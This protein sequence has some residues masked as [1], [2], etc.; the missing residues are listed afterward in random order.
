MGTESRLTSPGSG[1]GSVRPLS[2]RELL[3]VGALGSALALLPRSL[4]AET[5][6]RPNIL[7]VFIDDL[8]A[9]ALGC[10]GGLSYETPRIDALAAGGLRFENCYANPT[11]TPSRGTLL[12]G[13][14]P[15]RIGM[16]DRTRPDTLLDPSIP[17]FAGQLR[18]AGYRTA[19]SGK[20]Q[21]ARLD[22]RPEH[23]QECGFDESFLW[24]WRPFRGSRRYWGADIVHNGRPRPSHEGEYGPD[25]HCD[26]LIEF[27]ER[28][29]EAPFL[30]F[31][32]MAL[33]HNPPMPT[34][35]DGA[36]AW[37]AGIESVGD[38]MRTTYARRV[39]LNR[40]FSSMVTYADKL[41]GRLVDALDRLQLRERTLVIVCADNGTAPIIES[42]LG[43][44]MIRGGKDTLTEAGT[45]VPLVASWPGRVGGGVADDPVDLS[46]LYPTLADLAGIPAS[47]L[48]VDGVSLAPRLLNGEPSPRRAAFAQRSER[49]FMRDRRWRLH[50]DGALYDLRDRYS[51]RLADPGPESEAARRRLAAAGPLPG[52]GG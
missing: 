10:Y 45:R 49:W 25:L 1:R 51:E 7:F 39:F 24:N 31:Y 22:L 3:G 46:D 36:M 5:A 27:M 4:V 21:L 9:E 13:R 33:V 16:A 15:F 29:R 2:R 28:S 48:I 42:R 41:V 37:L 19:V 32:P 44:R 43:D 47:G 26:F 30:A 12:T 14:Y 34:P 35:D 50:H 18:S 17:T 8:G 52:V 40:W 6:Q 38:A 23:P 11:C 20:W